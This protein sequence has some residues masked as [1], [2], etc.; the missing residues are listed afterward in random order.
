MSTRARTSLSL[1]YF[2]CSHE[3]REHWSKLRVHELWGVQS[4][5]KVYK[6]ERSLHQITKKVRSFTNP[7][8]KRITA[9]INYSNFIIDEL[10]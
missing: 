9:L 7:S 3:L 6:S 4:G 2:D 1:V 5:P 10:I 8:I